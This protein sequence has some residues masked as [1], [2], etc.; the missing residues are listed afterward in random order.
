[1]KVTFFILNLILVSEQYPSWEQRE[2]K[3][4]QQTNKQTQT[5]V[6]TPQHNI[7]RPILF[8]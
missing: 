8:S 7:H 5:K 3:Q 1:M 2:G 4:T 6:I